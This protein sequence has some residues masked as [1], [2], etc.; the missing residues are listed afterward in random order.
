MFSTVIVLASLALTP[1]QVAGEEPLLDAYRPEWRS[2]SRLH[3]QYLRIRKE[4][5]AESLK[6]VAQLTAMWN[7]D[8][9]LQPRLAI[10]RD[11][12]RYTDLTCH[13]VGSICRQWEVENQC[14]RAHLSM[15]SVFAFPPKWILRNRAGVRVLLYTELLNYR[16]SWEQDPDEKALNWRCIN[17]LSDLL[18]NQGDVEPLLRQIAWTEALMT[19]LWPF[20]R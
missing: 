3:G 11:K 4:Y 5:E 8:G 14:L 15:G 19:E 2:M 7:N 12:V 13:K 10:L 20:L 16:W 9:P 17:S 18:G 1:A 6:R